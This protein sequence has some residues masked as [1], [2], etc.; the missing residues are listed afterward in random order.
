LTIVASGSRIGPHTLPACSLYLSPSLSPPPFRHHPPLSP[1]SFSPDSPL[2][3]YRHLHHSP[4]TLASFRGHSTLALTSFL[5]F[6]PPTLLPSLSSQ[7]SSLRYS[8]TIC[9][10]IPQDF[11]SAS[12]W[13]QIGKCQRQE[14]TASTCSTKSRGSKRRALK[15]IQVGGG[16]PKVVPPQ[17]AP[18]DGTG[19]P[20]LRNGGRTECRWAGLR[21]SRRGALTSRA[22]R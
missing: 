19:S 15:P 13:E 4:L 5:H 6:S 18:Q 16:E 2:W 9:D 14:S 20:R 22:A 10:I 7:A 3:L 8:L 17:A 12:F 1:P 11:C 21:H